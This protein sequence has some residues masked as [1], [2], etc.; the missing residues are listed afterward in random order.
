[1]LAIDNSPLAVY[2]IASG[3]GIQFHSTR[4]ANDAYGHN[5]YDLRIHDNIIHDTRCDGILIAT[6]SPELGPVTIYNNIIYNAGEGWPPGGGG[7]LPQGGG[8]FACINVTGGTQVPPDTNGTV[9][10][11]VYNNTLYNCAVGHVPDGAGFT[12][13]GIALGNYS[14]L[15]RLRARNNI[16][17]DPNSS[18]PYT[19]DYNQLFPPAGGPLVNLIGDHNLFFGSSAG[20]PSTGF[21]SSITS[22]PLFV[23]ATGHDFHLSS[24]SPAIQAGTTIGGLVSDLDGSPRPQLGAYD[25][26]AYEYGLGTGSGSIS[27][28]V[29]VTPATTSLVAG[30]QQQFTASVTG[31]TNTA[32]TWSLNPAFGAVSATGLYT[33]PVSVTSQQN[34]T[35]IATSVADVTKSSS[36]VITLTPT[37]PVTVS[38]SPSTS[39]LKAAQQQQFTASVTGTT[40]TTVTWSLNPVIGTIS[41]TGMYTAPASVTSQQNVTVTATSA[42]NTT[43]SAGATVALTLATQPVISA[44][45]ASSINCCSAIITWTTSVAADSQVDYGTTTSYGSSS[46][47]NS[48]QVYLHTVPLSNL[49]AGTLYHFRV[50]GRDVSGNLAT[51][52]DFTFTTAS[53]TS[54]YVLT[55]NVNTATTPPKLSVHWTTPSGR[56]PTDWI[57]LYPV[58]AGNDSFIRC[59]IVNSVTSG[60]WNVKLRLPSGNYEFRYLLDSTYVSVVTSNAITVP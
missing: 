37:T 26:G 4:Q 7:T 59:Y 8:D 57:A 6:I 5:L 40:N 36:S 19:V 15:L 56:P 31:A 28:S 38:V 30:Q 13:S 33:A 11:E 52:G 58:G 9:P 50:K 60:T 23:N 55:A 54:G 14:P 47:L 3:I 42:A 12:P 46:A 21:T 20:V 43:N 27:V 51:S 41:A 44:V 48:T 16:I 25:V 22:N 2:N 18:V 32:V 1:V 29:S 39:S 53:S 17:Y 10:V 34:V 24:G 49:Q 35:L 45:A